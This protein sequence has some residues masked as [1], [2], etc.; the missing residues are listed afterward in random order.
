MENFLASIGILFVSGTTYVAYKHPKLYQKS[1]DLKLFNGS[2]L[3]GAVWAFWYMATDYTYKTIKPL[4]DK[5][6]FEE[7]EQLLSS[8]QIPNYVAFIAL[9]ILFYS[10]FLSWLSFHFQDIH[11]D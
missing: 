3:V 8:V 5:S 11:D 4:I 9:S 2:I 10:L 7:A 1:F 6:K